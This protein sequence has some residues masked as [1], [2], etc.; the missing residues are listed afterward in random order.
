MPTGYTEPVQAGKITDFR[1]FAMSCARAFGATIT[2]RDDPSD[3]PIP[4]AFEPASYHSKNIAEVQKVVAKLEAMT[5]AEKAAS[6]QEAFEED[7]SEWDRYE[8][9]K[10]EGIARYQ[11]MLAAAEE[12]I[13]PT[14]EHVGLQEFML[15][16]LRESIEFDGGP[17]YRERPTLKSADQWFSEA[18]Q[19]AHSDLAHYAEEFSKEIE[20][21][22]KRN[23][24][25][26]E[27]RAS[28]PPSPA[29]GEDRSHEGK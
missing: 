9:K 16:Q 6:A 24:W 10:A 15:K 18:L 17:P 25:I 19:K 7:A 27:L 8:A 13:P 14:S 5:S 28:L 2:M 26:R 4:E 21:V 1:E 29:R 3:A 12:W 23:E 11:S 20:R 22:R